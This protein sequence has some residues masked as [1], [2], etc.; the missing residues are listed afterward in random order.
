[1]T[2]LINEKGNTS[3]NLFELYQPAKHWILLHTLIPRHTFHNSR[4][5]CLLIEMGFQFDRNWFRSALNLSLVTQKVS[6]ERPIRVHTFLVY[7]INGKGIHM[8]VFTA[9][10]GL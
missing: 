4:E 5:L 7:K 6:F 3:I 9:R 2:T 1:M 10:H 8:N